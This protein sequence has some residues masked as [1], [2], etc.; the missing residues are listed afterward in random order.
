MKKEQMNG[1]L[2]LLGIVLAVWAFVFALA[3]GS[4]WMW[5]LLF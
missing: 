1:C 5:H 3:A 4:K 2:T